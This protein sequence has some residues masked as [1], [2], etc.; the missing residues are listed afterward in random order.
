MVQSAGRRRRHNAQ[1][2][3]EFGFASK[4]LW[5]TC[6]APAVLGRGY[7]EWDV[8]S[9]PSVHPSPPFTPFPLP[10][11]S[12][13]FPFPTIRLF[14][15][16]PPLTCSSYRA[17]LFPPALHYALR[18][19]GCAFLPG[20]TL[21]HICPLTPSKFSFPTIPT[22]SGHA[23]HYGATALLQAGAGRAGSH[24]RI[25]GPG[26]GSAQGIGQ[27]GRHEGAAGRLRGKAQG[28][29]QCV[30]SGGKGRRGVLLSW[31]GYCFGSCHLCH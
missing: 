13:V 23:T 28:V 18:L 9:F 4:K 19:C 14:S 16:A 22:T 27:K 17:I 21:L 2:S 5:M 12:H 3:L 24:A 8:E 11:H 6:F 10:H 31:G 7:S 20:P 30:W 26:R 15:P 25:R 1:P 29:W